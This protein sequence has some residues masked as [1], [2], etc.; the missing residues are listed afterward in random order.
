MKLTK[1]KLLLTYASY[2]A[3]SLCIAT[4]DKLDWPNLKYYLYM[5]V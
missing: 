3:K 2:Y 5:R 4:E 1:Y